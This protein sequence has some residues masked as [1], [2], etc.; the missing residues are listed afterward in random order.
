VSK[1]LRVVLLAMPWML[2]EIV[3]RVT[4]PEPDI[5][6]MGEDSPCE[7]PSQ[8]AHI[9]AMTAEARHPVRECHRPWLDSAE[10]C[11]RGA[12]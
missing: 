3:N 7:A 4:G 8:P 12:L 10:R 6:V 1:T 5:Q 2:R 9:A 11:E